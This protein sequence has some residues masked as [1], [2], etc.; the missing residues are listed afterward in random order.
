MAY[1][2]YI[3]VPPM[4]LLTAVLQQAAFPGPLS[5]EQDELLWNFVADLHAALLAGKFTETQLLAAS[6][7]FK[8]TPRVPGLSWKGLAETL[9]PRIRGPA[10][11]LVGHRY[12]RL[13]N[14]Q[15]AESFFRVAVADAQRGSPLRRLAETEL[16]RLTADSGPAKAARTLGLLAAPLGNG[17]LVAAA[18]LP[19][20]SRKGN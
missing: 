15:D 3:R 2:E 12:L 20:E 14:P 7:T 19:V 10:A 4:L 5:P 16:M 13:G 6:L 11:Y 1:V 18:I 8:G 9:E 17:P